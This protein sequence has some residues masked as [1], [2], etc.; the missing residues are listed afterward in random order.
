MK[1]TLWNIQPI[2]D[3]RNNENNNTRTH[4]HM[5]IYILHNE[6]LHCEIY[7][8]THIIISNNLI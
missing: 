8:Y 2:N 3:P 7:I 5:H 4:I 1:S 6:K